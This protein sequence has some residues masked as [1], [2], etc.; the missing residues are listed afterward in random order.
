[1]SNLVAV[2]LHGPLADKYGGE[3]HFAIHS[4]REAVAALDA[5]YPGFRSDFLR[6]PTYGLY[7][8][9][10]WRDETNTENVADSPVSR[11][12]DFAP[13]VEGRLTAIITP[14]VASLVGVGVTAN[15]IGGVI[16]VG[17]LLGV[18]LLLTKKAKKK[19]TD[20]AATSQDNYMFSGPENVTEQ[21]TA[22]P[23]VYG[24]CFVGSVV[25]S[26]GLEV[27]EGVGSGGNDFEWS[28]ASAFASDED[29]SAPTITDTTPPS[30]APPPPAPPPGRSPP[31]VP[32]NA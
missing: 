32:E 2:R 18:S 28:R 14:V 5:N 11:Q 3:H 19:T 1:M 13:V 24:Q 27:A 4:P 23:L 21:G 20:D 25:V 30:N 9:G 16:A 7:V 26:A 8:D 17:L 10:D 12:I 31:Y 15:I 22:V 29:R 6:H